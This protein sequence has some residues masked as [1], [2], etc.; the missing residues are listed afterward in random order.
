ME[1]RHIWGALAGTFFLLYLWEKARKQSPFLGSNP[2]G[3]R[4]SLDTDR[5]IDSAAPW[6]DAH[7][8]VK[9]LARHTLKGAFRHVTEKAG[10]NS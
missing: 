1:R 4:L 6:I 8:V 10:F 5:V 3:V 7:P 9:D 2:D